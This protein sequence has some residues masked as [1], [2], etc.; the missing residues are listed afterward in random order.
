MPVAA[1]FL[2]RFFLI[3]SYNLLQTYDGHPIDYTT[4]KVAGQPHLFSAA[5]KESIHVALLALALDGNDR[6]LTFVL[7]NDTCM[8]A[9]VSAMQSVMRLTAFVAP[10]ISR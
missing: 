9:C 3:D 8:C 7:N 5:S 10:M 4:G 1:Y 2:Q 6:A